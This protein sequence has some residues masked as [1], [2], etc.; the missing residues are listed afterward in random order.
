MD[1]RLGRQRQPAHTAT[2]LSP[3]ARC[4][5]AHGRLAQ[6]DRVHENRQ[7]ARPTHATG[8][9]HADVVL[10]MTAARY[11]WALTVA[12]QRH[13]VG[14]SNL[15]WTADAGRCYDNPSSVRRVAQVLH[16]VTGI[17]EGA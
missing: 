10:G 8:S 7:Q 2:T 5:A 1:A 17:M 6:G 14:G 4:R 3:E 16:R 11:Q 15:L 12:L 9:P 13:P